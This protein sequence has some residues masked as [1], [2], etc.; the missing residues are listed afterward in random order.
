MSPFEMVAA[1]LRERFAEVRA[2]ARDAGV[3]ACTRTGFVAV[4][5]AQ[6]L[7]EAIEA[8]DVIAAHPEAAGEYLHL[9]YVLYRMWEADGAERTVSRARLEPALVGPAPERPPVPPRG[10]CY[11]DLPGRWI[12]AQVEPAA[13]HEPLDGIFVAAEPTGVELTV[14]AVLGAHERRSGFS[15]ISALAHR[16]DFTEA[17]HL[18]RPARFAPTMDGGAQAGFRSVASVAELLLLTHLALDRAGA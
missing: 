5:A 1:P 6:R 18:V 12:W 16:R 8:P 10:V 4:P 15:Q 11:L 2:E 7:L 3:D 17:E 9:L 13:A 14:L